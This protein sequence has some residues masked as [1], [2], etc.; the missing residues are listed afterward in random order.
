MNPGLFMIM[1]F[2]VFSSSVL[3][4]SLFS[5]IT[6]MTSHYIVVDNRWLGAIL[7][8]GAGIITGAGLWFM[9][10]P[11]TVLISGFFQEK[12]VKRVEGMYYPE[13]GEIREQRVVSSFLHSFLFTM[14]AIFLNFL[15]LPFYFIGVGF[16]ASII[17]NSYLLGREFF[18]AV[19]L[20]HG[21]RNEIRL[22][23]KANR[24]K[25]YSG[26]FMITLMTLLPVMN[27]FVPLLAIVWMVH[28]YHGL[29]K[30]MG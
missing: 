21:G 22:I 6:W 26:G 20:C 28:V 23:R 25:I 11:L 4:L 10:P 24:K 9:L 1:I 14:E 7:K 19:A 3:V 5:V 2:C 30:D 8:M 16:V 17:L 27:L 29:E 12:V 15:I 18:D 13:A